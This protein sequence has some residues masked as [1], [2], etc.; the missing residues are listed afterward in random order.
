M[1]KEAILEGLLFVVGEDGLTL[2][3]ISDV[4]EISEEDASLLVG[5]LK[6][7]YLDDNR[8]LRIDFLGN[9]LKLTTKVEHKDYYKKLLQREDSNEL[10][11]AALET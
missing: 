4:L 10:S 9:R 1:N 3:Q 5:E 6:N 11:Q 2:K 8:G 7:K